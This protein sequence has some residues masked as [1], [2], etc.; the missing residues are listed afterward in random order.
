MQYVSRIFPETRQV[1]AKT[2]GGLYLGSLD[3]GSE[4]DSTIFKTFVNI[5]NLQP[6]YRA[7][8]AAL[9]DVGL[10][11]FDQRAYAEMVCG[12][13]AVVTDVEHEIIKAVFGSSKMDWM[14]EEYE[15][16]RTK[17]QC[18]KSTE[19]NETT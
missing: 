9:I 10:D 19:Q 1:F 7:A 4:L 2:R 6:K 16:R 8:I 13:P 12:E 14:R 15:A 18:E 11:R 3:R 5:E 17:D